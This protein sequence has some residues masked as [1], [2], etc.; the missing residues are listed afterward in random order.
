M[1]STAGGQAYWCCTWLT[2]SFRW[3]LG[4]I[5]FS[6]TICPA[7][8]SSAVPLLRDFPAGCS[9]SICFFVAGT[10]KSRDDLHGPLV[11]WRSGVG[12]EQG[13]EDTL[14]CRACSDPSRNW[15]VIKLYLHHL[16]AGN[17]AETASAPS[18]TS[19]ATICGSSSSRGNGPCCSAYSDS[20]AAVLA[21]RSG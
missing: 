11:R 4:W 1:N 20:R 14:R 2:S 3:S 7:C 13:R 17:L 12:G 21:W 5:S 18:T 19:S 8:F 6:L 10:F 9:C 15:I 16:F